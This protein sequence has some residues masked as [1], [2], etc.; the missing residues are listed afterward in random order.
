[1]NTLFNLAW[2][3][4][5]NR[6]S[7]ALLTI[8]SIA[9]GVALLLGIEQL[10]QSM[11]SSFLR[12]VSGIDL[13][14]GARGDAIPLMLYSVFRLG[15]A[16][17]NIRWDSYLNWAGDPRVEWTI[18]FSLGDSHKGF[19]VLGSS[20]SYWENYR[21][22]KSRKLDLKTGQYF[23]GLYDAVI[24]A[25]V[26]D[27]L[28]Y[29][30]NQQIVIAHGAG[31]AAIFEH[32]DQPFQVVGILKPT[33][34]LVDDTIH[35]S[36][37]AIEAIHIGWEDGTPSREAISANQ[38]DLSQLQPKSI[39]AFLV[40]LRSKIQTFRVQSQINQ[41]EKEPLSAILPG[42]TMHKLWKI[43]GVFE[44][45]L[46]AVSVLVI[47]SSLTSLVSLLLAS[48]NERRREM[49]ILRSV[50]AGPSTLFFLLWIEATF[51]CLFGVL[52][53]FVIQYLGLFATAPIVQ[54]QFGIQILLHWPG[55][56]ESLIFVTIIFV[57]MLLSLFPAWRAYRI[58]LHD[59]LLPKI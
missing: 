23:T 7:T 46:I 26:A 19:R 35:V 43:L 57:G 12:T 58:S 2:L 52:L 31:N 44:K 28:N 17:N 39:T 55:M 6:K 59:G 13:V 40:K 21:Y 30:L 42:V 33:G 27:K 32:D 20:T 37:E 8:L 4:L 25:V 9:I 18:P 11:R 14:V 22:G 47:L 15:D 45:T 29:K 34:T 16:T 5:I 1:M 24:G 56:E 36:L 48:L 10:R 50:G 38:L 41:Y 53:G 49:A 3:S 54:N 51:L